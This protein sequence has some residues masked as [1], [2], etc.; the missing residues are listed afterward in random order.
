MVPFPSKPACQ[1]V[2]LIL[3]AC[4][5][6]R[7]TIAAPPKT[8]KVVLK[9][10]DKQSRESLAVRMHLKDAK[11]KAVRPPDLP[12]WD[13]HFVFDGEITLDL[14]PGNYAFELE[15]GPE[16]K[17][18][19]GN[20]P[21]ARK[22]DGYRELEMERILIM[23]GEGWWSGDLHVHRRPEEIELLMRAEELHVA[24]VITWWND[25]NLFSD[26]GPPTMP[27]VAFDKNRFYHLM[28]GEDERAGG[29]LLY[30]H[31]TQ[32]LPIATAG[33]EHPTPV[34]FLRQARRHEGVH[35]DIEKPF[36]W[37]MPTW[38]ATGQV[39]SIGI[40]HNHMQ[41]STVMGNE[42]WG[43]AR[44]KRRYPD[45]LGNGY[46]TQQ[47]YYHLLNAGL[48]IP[49]SAG[50]AS[51][52]LK[53]PVGYN[54]VY[55]HCAEELTW[56]RWWEGLRAGRVV[57]S[58]GP[59][60][61]PKVNGHPPGHVFVGE[62]GQPL[63]LAMDLNLAL[64]DP[65]EYLE[66]VKD[67]IIVHEVRLDEYANRKGRLPSVKFTE[68]GWM[69]VRVVTQA[70]GTFRFASSGPYYVQVNDRPRISRDSASF[71]LDWVN[72][73]IEMVKETK[74]IK[75]EKQRE[76]VLAPHVA[77]RQFWEERVAN[78]NAP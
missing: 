21:V 42:A 58:N 33:R 9:V 27:L 7:F 29:A 78:A 36:W 40:C 57:V 13:D 23:S 28:A 46:W 74:E 69:L 31:L 71:F 76:E 61:R 5:L 20:F 48:R 45:P 16:Y 52:V 66:I 63:E 2:I 56:E 18:L 70:P 64:R 6:P 3:V 67:G 43:K 50:S 37:D 32:P 19:T 55:V 8:G 72:E 75:D 53:N 22:S 4:G 47:I 34:D 54:R 17:L 30:F 25:R 51:G 35:V 49:P 12:F 15:R 44:D 26:R 68:S 60:L 24:P 59:L 41:R 14:P 39:D 11:G 38:V 73:R 1:A 77:A 62:S 65:A 10:V